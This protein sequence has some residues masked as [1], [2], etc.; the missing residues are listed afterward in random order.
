[1]W[2]QAADVSRLEGSTTWLRRPAR[3]NRL[4]DGPSPISPLPSL[5]GAGAGQ[6]TMRS[7]LHSTRNTQVGWLTWFPTP[8]RNPLTLPARAGTARRVVRFR[9]PTILTTTEV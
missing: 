8:G 9:I 3:A 4:R 1:M 2:G 7:N 5:T 6:T